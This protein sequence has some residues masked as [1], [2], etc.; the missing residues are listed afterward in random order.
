MVRNIYFWSSQELPV[1]L[2]GFRRCLEVN[3][4]LESV[5][6][7]CFNVDYPLTCLKAFQ[8]LFAEYPHQTPRFSQIYGKSTFTIDNI[9][10]VNAGNLDLVINN[11]EIAKGYLDNIPHSYTVEVG[12]VHLGPDT[13][14]DNMNSLLRFLEARSAVHLR[15]EDLT[16]TLLQQLAD[17][18]DVL[19]LN[20]LS[21]DDLKGFLGSFLTAL[22]DRCISTAAK[23]SSSAGSPKTLK[24]QIAMKNMGARQDRSLYIYVKGMRAETGLIEEQMEEL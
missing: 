24:D 13:T 22:V 18:I 9:H 2:D 21:I 8:E 4:G 16:I 3:V 11:F 23:I 12:V 14:S 7:N 10:D 17:A 6:V 1:L 19:T 5:K 20:C 15:C